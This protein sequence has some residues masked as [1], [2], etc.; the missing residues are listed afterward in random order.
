MIADVYG[1]RREPRSVSGL[2]LN[3]YPKS[4]SYQIR[5][6]SCLTYIL[7]KKRFVVITTR[8]GRAA[9][10]GAAAV[11]EASFAFIS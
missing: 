4:S 2:Y 8:W 11:D 10:P 7:G 3:F 6:Q 5:I 9:V 1:E